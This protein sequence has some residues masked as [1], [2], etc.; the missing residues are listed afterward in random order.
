MLLEL[1]RRLLPPGA[2]LD[3]LAREGSHESVLREPAEPADPIDALAA[4]DER[5]AVARKANSRGLYSETRAS[6]E[7][8]PMEATGPRH[9]GPDLRDTLHDQHLRYTTISTRV[10]CTCRFSRQHSSEWIKNVNIL[11]SKLC[12]FCHPTYSTWRIV[13]GPTLQERAQQNPRSTSALRVTPGAATPSDWT[14]KVKRR[15]R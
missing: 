12:L 13:L 9:S 3:G 1:D 6:G 14:K 5:G 7:I 11:L 10:L 2:D 15:P 4:R 8:A